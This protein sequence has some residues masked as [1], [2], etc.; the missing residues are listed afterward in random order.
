MRQRNSNLNENYLPNGNKLHSAVATYS[1]VPCTL[2]PVHSL[3][4]LRRTFSEIHISYLKPLSLTRDAMITPML[5]DFKRR[6]EYVFMPTSDVFNHIGL[7]AAACL[8]YCWIV[9]CMC[10]LCSHADTGLVVSASSCK[11]V[12]C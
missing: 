3:P 12:H 6:F 9:Y 8:L 11:N 4:A 2:L 1:I 7:T 10:I 5:R